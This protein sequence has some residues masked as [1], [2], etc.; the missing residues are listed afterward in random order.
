MSSFHTC[1]LFAMAFVALSEV[2]V[3]PAAAQALTASEVSTIEVI[4]G[5]VHPS[6]NTSLRGAVILESNFESSSEGWTAV[7]FTSNCRIPVSPTPIA[8]PQF[9]PTGGVNDGYITLF[10]GG[11]ASFQPYFQAPDQYRGDLSPAYGGAIAMELRYTHANDRIYYPADDI[12]LLGNGITLIANSENPSRDQWGYRT[13]PLLADAWRINACDGPTPTESEF[14][15]VLASVEE[16]FIRAEYAGGSESLALDQFAITAESPEPQ[17]TASWHE[18]DNE[19]PTGRWR[20][21]IAID[22]H[23]NILV[24]FGGDTGE[25]DTWEYDLA[26]RIWTRTQPEITPRRRGG[27]AMAYDAARQ[28][29]VMTGGGYISRRFNEVWEYDTVTDRWELAAP[30]DTSRTGHAMAYDSDRQT[31]VIYGGITDVNNPSGTAVLERSSGSDQWVPRPSDINPGYREGIAIAYDQSRARTVLVGNGD[32]SLIVAEW[33]GQLGSWDMRDITGNVPSNRIN[34]TLTY[35]A[36]NARCVLVGGQGFNSAYSYD[37]TAWQLISRL[38]NDD[39]RDEHA[40]AYHPATG[41]ILVSGGILNSH[42]PQRDILAMDGN[43]NIWTTEWSQSACGPRDYFA[44]VFDEQSNQPI[45]FGGGLVT[46][47][48]TDINGSGTFA[49][50]GDTWSNLPTTGAVGPRWF[51]PMVYDPERRIALLYGGTNGSLNTLASGSTG[52]FWK[53]DL[54]TLQWTESTGLTPGRRHNHAAMYDRQRGQ[55]VVHGGFDEAAVRVD[56]TAIYTSATD[57]W[58]VLDASATTPGPRNGAG[59][60][61]DEHRGV[62]VL[63]G[64]RLGA[65]EV[66]DNTTWEWDGKQWT[67]VT[68]PSGNPPARLTPI[69]L[70]NPQRQT[71]LMYGGLTNRNANQNDVFEAAQAFQDLW[72]WDGIAWKPIVVENAFP[73]GLVGANAAFDRA[74]NRTVHFGGKSADIDLYRNGQTYSLTFSTCTNPCLADFN[75]DGSVNILDVLGFIAEWN[76]AGP[77]ADFNADGSINILD[78]LAFITTWNAGCP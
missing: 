65:N 49:F 57:T 64:G 71:V 46:R 1:S 6:G 15:A 45:V 10:D 31:L 52:R 39:G 56:Q 73:I 3:L 12:F 23:R 66:W 51:A 61:F 25:T 76:A 63:F 19:A 44:M 54:E 67:D 77:S 26:T 32:T 22:T 42:T 8:P 33:N 41:R 30:L 27:H 58:A 18:L 75:A 68:P 40:A 36:I 55:M 24:L 28:R 13:I 78:V 38:P 70:Y 34:P 5:S 14:R 9:T 2:A 47:S 35:D 72:E 21:A 20:H 50:D 60:A 62:G 59:F 69:M 74:N 4:G 11:A 16:I 17:C 53:L 43:T 7:S 48:P 29:I 37:G